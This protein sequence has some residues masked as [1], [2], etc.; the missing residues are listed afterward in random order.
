MAVIDTENRKSACMQL[1]QWRKDGLV[2]SQFVL[3]VNASEQ[4]LRSESLNND[5]K[6]DLQNANLTGECLTVEVTESV[7]VS[8][9]EKQ[10]QC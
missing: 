7:L 10:L 9:F 3:A 4:L 1:A 6:L 5:I 8:D 2:D